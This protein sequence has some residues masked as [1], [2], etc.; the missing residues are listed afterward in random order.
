MREMGKCHIPYPRSFLRRIP[1]E[2]LEHFHVLAV[3]L[4]EKAP[5]DAFRK[6][7]VVWT[8]Y[9]MRFK[10]LFDHLVNGSATIG[11]VDDLLNWVHLHDGMRLF[12]LDRFDDYFE[13]MREAIRKG[14][15]WVHYNFDWEDAYVLEHDKTLE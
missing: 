9:M 4:A 2:K 14:T 11:E 6:A 15:P 8:E 3:A 1:M 7:L 5:S 10:R 12:V 13:G